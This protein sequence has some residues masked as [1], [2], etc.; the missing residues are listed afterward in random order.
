MATR[1]ELFR[2]EAEQASQRKHQKA[3]GARQPARQA[4]HHESARAGK[5]ATY[6]LED[7]PGRRPSRKSTRK[8]SN[9]QKN[10]VQF[11]MKRQVSEGRPA[12]RQRTGTR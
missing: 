8:A 9:R 4:V 11:R 1:A 3:L 7:A 2:A 5:H 12:T 6:A 10:D